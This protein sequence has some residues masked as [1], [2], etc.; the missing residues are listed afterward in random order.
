MKINFK[1]TVIGVLNGGVT[2]PLVGLKDGAYGD[3]S[4]LPERLLSVHG[5]RIR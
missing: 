5:F 1:W 3:I 2:E 4:T